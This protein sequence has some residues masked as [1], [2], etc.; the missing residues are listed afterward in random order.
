MVMPGLTDW[1]G[2]VYEGGAKIGPPCSVDGCEE[3][4]VRHS[5]N[6]ERDPHRTHGHGEIHSLASGTLRPYCNTHGQ[7]VLL[8]NAAI[9]RERAK[10]GA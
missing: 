2:N 8:R 1:R 5:C 6:A 9:Q 10:G 7:E 3:D 4:A